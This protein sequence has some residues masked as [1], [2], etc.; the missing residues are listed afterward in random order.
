[1]DWVDIALHAGIAA[2][3]VALASLVGW[4]WHAVPLVWVAF[5]AREASQARRK[6]GRW[7][8]PWSTQKWL[9]AMAPLPAGMIAAAIAAALR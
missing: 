6:Y 7:L 8:A 2:A 9:E 3:A 4:H 1:M 5:A